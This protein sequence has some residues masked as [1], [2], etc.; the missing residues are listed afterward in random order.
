MHS[1]KFWVRRNYESGSHVLDCRDLVASKVK[2]P[3]I[4][5]VG[6]LRRLLDELRS[7][8]HLL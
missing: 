3:L 7:D 1:K 8:F 6:K 5:R 4:K 2:L